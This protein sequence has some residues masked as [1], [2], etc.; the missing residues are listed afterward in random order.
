MFFKCVIVFGVLLV[1]SV[2]NM[3]CFV[4]EVCM[5]IL[6]V[7]RLWI[8]LIRILLG[9]WWRI[10]CKYFVKVI[11]MLELMGICMILL[12]L[13]L[14]GFL[15]VI[16]LFLIWFNLESVEYRVVVLLELVGLVINM[17]LFGFLMMFWKLVIVGIF[18][19]ILFKLSEIIE[20]FSIW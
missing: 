13:Y 6:V 17:I 14:I 5:V 16:N 3:R 12:M 9:F 19:L 20:W 11:L 1:C 8:F 4:S 18:M 7:L 15:V 2:L 10:V